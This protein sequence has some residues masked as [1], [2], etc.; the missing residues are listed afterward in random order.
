MRYRGTTAKYV[1]GSIYAS[2]IDAVIY[3]KSVVEIASVTV[4]GVR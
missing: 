1:V 3:V 4:G 2:T